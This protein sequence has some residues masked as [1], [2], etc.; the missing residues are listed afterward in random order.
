MEM[1]FVLFYY[2]QAWIINILS[3]MIKQFNASFYQIYMLQLWEQV[4]IA[5][6]IKAGKRLAIEH[7]SY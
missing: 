5:F 4:R 7:K 2:S 6:I 3:A 1:K